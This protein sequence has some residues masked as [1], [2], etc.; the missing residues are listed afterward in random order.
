M[1]ALLDPPSRLGL[2]P[3][4]L[5][6]LG[7]VTVHRHGRA[8]APWA[9]AKL[10]ALLALLGD[11]GGRPVARAWGAAL[12][13][14]D[15][16]GASLRRALYDLRRQLRTGR[17]ELPMVASSRQSVWLDRSVETD[18]DPID[19][20]W[21]DAQCGRLAPDAAEAAL[22]GWEGEFAAGLSVPGADDFEL[23]LLQARARWQQRAL[24][25]TLAVADHRLRA[26][27]PAPALAAA[28]RAVERVP[29]DDAAH[30]LLW[31]CQ[32]AAGQPLLAEQDWRLH[33]AALARLQ[34]APSAALCAQAAALGLQAAEPAAA[35]ADD[36][37]IRA[38]EHAVRQ[39][40]GGP[41]VEALLHEAETRLQTAPAGV[42]LLRRTFMLRLLHSPWEAPMARLA[43]IAERL[44]C[45]PLT[46]AQ[47]LDVV[48]PL[49]TWH[50]WMGRGVRGEVLLRALGGIDDDT[51]PAAT[52]VRH[53]M[54]LALCHS[55]STGDPARS[56]RAAQ[57]GL[58][59]AREFDV[60]ASRAAM[61]MLVANAA[62]N[63]DAPGDAAVAARA[64]AQAMEGP[65]LQ[66]FDLVNHHQLSAQW[67]LAHGEPARALAE[68][69]QGEALGRAVPFPLQQ[70]SCA[71]L[72]IAAHLLLGDDGQAAALAAAEALA[73][74]IGSQG[75]LMNALF[76]GAALA[77]RQGDAVL[78]A[79]RRGEAL[80]IARACGAERIRKVPPRLLQEA[81][82]TG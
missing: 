52:R 64:L 48:Q 4:R 20:A 67:Q 55:C 2:S 39:G 73:R 38:L 81:L 71:L 23:W 43:A 57:R 75:Y 17:A 24:A 49:A 82:S 74:R 27:R 65:P 53:Q 22:A 28:R 78:A 63:R 80:A 77:H 46:D 70:L 3:S 58:Q 37:L 15:K 14:P 50:G 7:P 11:A 6:L 16:D 56:I 1:S 12:L 51:L 79:S 9:Y 26:G 13:W 35:D 29:E 21:R 25:L 66:R 33:R 59:I 61:L 40:P 19:R 72:G 44:L 34:L 42:L 5:C 45:T 31:R 8:N 68:A 62:L 69:E 36:A 10:P 76:V 47:R 32:R 60:P 54:T 41:A 18:L 30:A